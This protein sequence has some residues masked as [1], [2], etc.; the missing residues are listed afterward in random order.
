MAFF[1]IWCLIV[2]AI[3]ELI[4]LYIFI[5]T[6]NKISLAMGI[7]FLVEVFCFNTKFQAV[8]HKVVVTLTVSIKCRHT[9][10]KM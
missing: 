9:L 7:N 5:T 3:S 10:T 4:S 8:M 6:F 2:A 1:S